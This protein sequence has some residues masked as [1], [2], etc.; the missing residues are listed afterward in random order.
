MRMKKIELGQMINI[1]ANVG[2]IA[3]I[4]F[5]AIEVGQNQASLEEANRINRAATLSTAVEHFSVFRTSLAEDEQLAQ[6]WLSGSSGQ[7]LNAVDAQRYYLMC[8]TILWTYV[9]MHEQYLS[10]GQDSHVQGP[11]TSMRRDLQSPGIRECWDNKVKHDVRNWG[12]D[13]FLRAMEKPKN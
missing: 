1:L 2:V 13:S 12:Y 9:M 3:G 5:L 7:E 8:Q 11:I 10:L 4:A 6:I